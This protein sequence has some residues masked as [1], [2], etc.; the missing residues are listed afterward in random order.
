MDTCEEPMNI[1]E[2]IDYAVNFA[3]RWKNF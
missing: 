1:G 2:A 3:A